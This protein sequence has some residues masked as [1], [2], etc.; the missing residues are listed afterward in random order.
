M[1]APKYVLKAN[2]ANMRICDELDEQQALTHLLLDLAH[3]GGH[4]DA[5]R[6]SVPS[7]DAWPHK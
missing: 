1:N 3:D 6:E 2:T 5:A 4:I 7:H